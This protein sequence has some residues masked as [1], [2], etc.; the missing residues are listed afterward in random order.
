MRRLIAPILVSLLCGL[1]PVA[2]AV[3]SAGAAAVTL[4]SVKGGFNQTPKISFPTGTPPSTLHVSYLH[5]GSGPAVKSGQLLVANDLGQIW[6]G[7]IFDNSF[8]RKQLS[9][10]PIGVGAVIHGWDLGLIGVPVGSRVLLVIPPVD[11][12]GPA[13]NPQAGITGSNTIVF[14]IDIV[15]AY[16]KN[17]LAQAN[18]RVLR[19]SVDGVTIHASGNLQP[20]LSIPNK[21]PQPTT[22]KMTEL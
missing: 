21:T 7:K 17:Y 1:A 8:A 9:G 18:P 13:G 3:T 19:T 5:R 12:Y 4:P 10:F 14:V 20:S 11:G 22:V 16:G 2:A 15:A 6:R